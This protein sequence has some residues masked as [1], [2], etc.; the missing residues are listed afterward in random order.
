MRCIRTEK[1][2]IQS[3]DDVDTAEIEQWSQVTSYCGF[4]KPYLSSANR[5]WQTVGEVILNTLNLFIKSLGCVGP[6]IHFFHPWRDG[7][8]ARVLIFKTTCG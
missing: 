2:E 8:R 7:S 1:S 6:P 4:S 3:E 5:G